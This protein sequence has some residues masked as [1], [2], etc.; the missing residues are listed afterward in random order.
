MAL[1]LRT[2]PFAVALAAAL[3]GVLAVLQPALAVGASLALAFVV[4]MIADLSVG[5]CLFVFAAS[6]FE[7]VPELGSVSVAKVLGLILALSWIA[8]LLVRSSWRH[9]LF[10]AFPGYTALLVVFTTWCLASGLWAEDPSAA[11]SGSLRIGLNLLILPIAY[12]A[13]RDERRL[14][15]FLISLLAGLV[16]SSLY[17]LLLSGGDPSA[18]GRLQGAGFDPNY[19][20]LWLVAA[21]TLGIGVATRRRMDPAARALVLAAVAVSGVFVL[22][23]ASRT[24]LVALA[25]VT[26]LSP[27]AL[28]QGRRAVAVLVGLVAVAGCLTYFVALAPPAVVEH[29]VASD[30]GSGRTDIWKV[31]LRMVDAHPVRG[32]GLGNYP[33]TAVHYLF[34]PGD[35]ANTDL[36]IDEP[37][38]SHNTYLGLLAELG[39]IGLGMY[40][41]ILLGAVAATATAARRLRAAGRRNEELLARA[42]LLAMIAVA[43][44]SF[45]VSLEYTK[46][47][48][49]LLALGPVTLRL[50]GSPVREAPAR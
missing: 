3:L 31:G 36:I 27:F 37:K 34:E 12:A 46:P 15:W 43:A 33:I 41:A 19:L 38:V 48:W 7:A 8:S 17:G 22:S 25:A 16:G 9:Q 4:L 30:G 49:L 2:L 1:P 23:T 14:R 32:I 5:L 29:V 42:V 44:G 28:G 10:S 24:G 13:I 21:G 45:F 11:L 35:L 6:F 50:S 18:P 26:L 40:L 39:V 47:L 20:A